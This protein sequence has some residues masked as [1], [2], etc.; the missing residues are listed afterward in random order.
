MNRLAKIVALGVPLAAAALLHTAP[1]DACG[2][3][4]VPPA[5]NTIVSGHRMALSISMS[6]TVLWDQIEY[7]GNPEDFSWVLPIKPG[8]RI[9]EATPEWFE[10]LE[11]SST[12]GVQ[13]PQL[14]CNGGGAFACGSQQT[15]AAAGAEDDGTGGGHSVTVVKAETV[16]PYESV[17]LSSKDAGALTAW[18]D[19]HG[20]AIPDEIQPVIGAYVQGGFDFIALRLTP[21][22]GVNLMKPVRVITDGAS[23]VLPLRMVAAGTGAITKVVLYVIGEGRWEAQNFPNLLVPVEDLKW[24]GEANDSNYATLRDQTFLNSANMGWI[25]T[26]ARDNAFLGDALYDD[27]GIASGYIASTYFGTVLDEQGNNYDQYNQCQSQLGSLPSGGVVIDTCDPETKV[28][29]GVQP[30]QIDARQFTCGELTDLSVALTGMHPQ[31]V[32]VTRMEANLPRIAFGQDLELR[33]AADQVTVNNFHFATQSENYECPAV[34]A[35][36]SSKSSK[37]SKN[38]PSGNGTAL[39]IV[40]LGA[41]AA[42]LAMRRGRFVRA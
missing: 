31:N 5:A 20:Y 26:Y 36:G 37:S 22:N 7:Q 39:V 40:G 25:T 41:V 6:R 1:A 23:P 42:L 32:W 15:F 35:I 30:G 18:L 19:S 9:E 8:A 28:C 10:A 29:G 38:G 12:T 27:E 3:C 2:G 33:A 17:T 16:G 11:A 13:A 4:F 24:D 14:N 34:P 21:G